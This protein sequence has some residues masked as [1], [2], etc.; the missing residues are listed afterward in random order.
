MR[1]HVYG[2]SWSAGLPE[3]ENYNSWPKE[4][5]KIQP[6]WQIYNFA[7]PGS[8]S[9][10]AMYNLFWSKQHVNE[11]VYHIYQSTS[12][13]RWTHMQTDFVP[14]DYLEKIENNYYSFF[15][16]YS[17]SIRDVIQTYQIKKQN[18]PPRT[19]SK[20]YK[21]KI[22]HELETQWELERFSHFESMRNNIDLAF[23]H[24]KQDQEKYN[25]YFDN[26]TMCIQSTLGDSR[27]YHYCIDK[28]MHFGKRGLQWQ[29]KYIRD[30]I[31][32]SYN[33]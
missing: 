7:C 20:H 5:A 22:K 31:K 13:Y 11:P 3:E 21:N 23:F 10:F 29:A 8:S 9:H 30:Y 6:D 18:K 24:R 32:G 17:G 16:K 27:F 28:G 1:I 14:I 26:D 4:L 25:S 19:L 12:Q 15:P 33:D 2:C